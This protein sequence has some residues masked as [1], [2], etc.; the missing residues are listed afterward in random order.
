MNLPPTPISS[1]S[2]KNLPRELSSET[3]GTGD[4][5]AYVAFSSAVYL[6]IGGEV[7]A[8]TFFYPT[9][10]ARKTGGRIHNFQNGDC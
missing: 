4:V 7:M 1:P 8:K 2:E 5:V 6:L 9:H 10:F 3:Y